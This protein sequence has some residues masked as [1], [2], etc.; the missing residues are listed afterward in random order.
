MPL[1]FSDI[2]GATG[3]AA[4]EFRFLDLPEPVHYRW[5]PLFVTPH[6]LE[7]AADLDGIADGDDEI[8]A[9]D[10]AR[11]QEAFLCEALASVLAGWDLLT[12]DGESWPTTQDGLARLPSVFIRALWAHIT[13][14]SGPNAE[15][16]P[17]SPATS[18]PE[19]SSAKR[20]GGTSS[21]GRL[22]SSGSRRGNSHGNRST[23]A[24][25]R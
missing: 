22:A 20:R 4:G 19:A 15:S 24:R 11:R 25:R 6:L 23:G 13:G 1:R 2:I 18:D 16:E 21:S 5:R 7:V 3:E 8:S 17:P 9:A 14:E 12:D 10:A